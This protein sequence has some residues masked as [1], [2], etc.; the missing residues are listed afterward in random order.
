MLAVG[1]CNGVVKYSLLMYCASVTVRLYFTQPYTLTNGDLINVC[2]DIFCHLF[3]YRSD[4]HPAWF[5]SSA[6]F[7]GM[8]RVFVIL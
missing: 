4:Y 8:K 5:V 3:A 1:A 6:A 7:L 2:V